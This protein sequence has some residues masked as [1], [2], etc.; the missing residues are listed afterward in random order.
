MDEVNEFEEE[1]KKDR[2]SLNSYLN[3]IYSYTNPFP[4]KQPTKKEINFWEFSGIKT[5]LFVLH[6][7]LFLME[8]SPRIF[9]LLFHLNTKIF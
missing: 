9:L 5:S 6:Q 7:L 8:N 2:E 1:T 3:N 4:Y